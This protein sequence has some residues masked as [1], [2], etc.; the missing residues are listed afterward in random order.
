MEEYSLEAQRA[1]ISLIWRLT[2]P[3][4]WYQEIARLGLDTMVIELLVDAMG[5]DIGLRVE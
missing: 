4:R 3:H 2:P 1:S 5:S